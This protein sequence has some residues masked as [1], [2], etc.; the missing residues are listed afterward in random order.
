[1]MDGRVV[2][3]AALAGL[4]L[5]V[6]CGSEAVDEPMRSAVADASQVDMCTILTDAELSGLGINPDTRKSVDELGVSGCKWVGMP[7]TLD[8]GRNEETVSEYAARKDLST[9]VYFME[10]TVNSRAGF[11]FSVTRA[12]PQCVQLLDGGSVSLRIA[13]AASSSLGSPIDA[14][15]EALR[16]AEMIEP[17]LPG[18]GK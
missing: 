17:R 6:G 7:F 8:L 9:F 1:M 4:M 16:I 3:M 12:L 14:C 5:M 13:V 15:A 11:Q 10:N 18:G 2:G